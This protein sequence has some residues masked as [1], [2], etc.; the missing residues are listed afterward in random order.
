M[1][2]SSSADS[3]SAEV[4]V[5]TAC[6]FEMIRIAQLHLPAGTPPAAVQLGVFGCCPEAQEGCTV[7]FTNFSIKHGI[8]FEHNADGNMPVLPSSPTSSPSSAEAE[9]GAAVQQRADQPVG[10]TRFFI[11]RHGTT[12]WNKKGLWQG[13][14]DTPLAPEGEAEA[15]KQSERFI[16]EEGVSFTHVVCSDL[17]RAHRTAEILAAPHKITPAPAPE[18]RECSLGKFEGMHK[19]DI[20]GQVHPITLPPPPF[21]LLEEPWWGLG[22]G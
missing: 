4:G 14:I 17:K 9:V 6:R 1:P 19:D 16:E 13:E 10:G 22:G 5:E 18:L 20:H 8:D 12:E 11:V 3:N 21:S 2:T 7:T 15:Q